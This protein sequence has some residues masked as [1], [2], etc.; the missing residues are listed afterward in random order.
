MLTA[1]KRGI[2]FGIVDR[3]HGRYYL[4]EVAKHR[5]RLSRLQHQNRAGPMSVAAPGELIE[6]GIRTRK[7]GKGKKGGRGGKS[8]NGGRRK[9]GN[10]KHSIGHKSIKKTRFARS[11]KSY[12][13]SDFYQNPSYKASGVSSIDSLEFYEGEDR[14]D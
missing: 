5:G 6:R 4:L 10:K 9:K 7:S 8:K 11:L 14:R 1:L 12:E 13:L 3:K 2:E